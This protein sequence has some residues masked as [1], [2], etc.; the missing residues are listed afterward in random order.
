VEDTQRTTLVDF[1]NLVCEDPTLKGVGE[2]KEEVAEQLADYFL[3][4]KKSEA[5]GEGLIL[6]ER[7]A[8]EVGGAEPEKL[9][10]YLLARDRDLAEFF[11]DMTGLVSRA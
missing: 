11:A 2:K 9:H 4:P 5:E 8:E 7:L 3:D 10:T 1:E 6:L